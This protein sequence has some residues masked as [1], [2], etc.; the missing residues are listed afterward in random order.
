MTKAIIR[1]KVSITGVCLKITVAFFNLAEKLHDSAK[2]L[3]SL[4]HH[5]IDFKLQFQPFFLL[6]SEASNQ[7]AASF[8]D[9][10]DFFTMQPQERAIVLKLREVSLV[11]YSGLA[12]NWSSN[13]SSL[14]FTMDYSIDG[15]H[16]IDYV[17]AERVKVKMNKKFLNE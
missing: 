10:H 13:S 8:E 4:R 15:F 17:E 11:Q 3:N 9:S 7:S 5:G 16:W 1:L 2:I 12:F 14:N 6:D